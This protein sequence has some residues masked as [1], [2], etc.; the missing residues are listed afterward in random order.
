MY[1]GIDGTGSLQVAPQPA[2][3]GNPSLITFC[4]LALE[5]Q[6]LCPLKAVLLSRKKW[7]FAVIE[8]LSVSSMD[9]LSGWVE[10]ACSAVLLSPVFLPFPLL[11]P[12]N[13]ALSFC[14]MFKNCRDSSLPLI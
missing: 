14:L 8:E 5:R 3:P 12:A 1:V 10:Q 9:C 11:S 7:V 4:V 6:E 2:V 13:G